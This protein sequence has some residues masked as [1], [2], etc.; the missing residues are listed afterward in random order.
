[1]VAARSMENGDGERAYLRRVI[2]NSFLERVLRIV[3][4]RLA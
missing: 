3:L 2:G 4:S 1:M